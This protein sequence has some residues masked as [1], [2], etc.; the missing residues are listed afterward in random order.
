MTSDYNN[1]GHG[2]CEGDGL[3]P[4]NPD[5]SPLV[6]AWTQLLGD[7]L[8]DK[9]AQW[10]RERK[11]IE[12][13]ADQIVARL[14]ADVAELR[15]SFE[16][17]LTE[18]LAALR[19]GR[20]GASGAPGQ[21]GPPGPRGEQGAPGKMS[22]CRDWVAG[23]VHYTGDVVCH[24]GSSWQALRDTGQEPGHLDWICICAGRRNAAH[25]RDLEFRCKI[26]QAGCR[27]GGRLLLCGAR[28]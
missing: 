1:N 8:A 18:R 12:A 6:D 9:Q 11:R 27:C 20:D 7:V 4:L 15:S 26:L 10:D 19:D 25:S 23:A 21:A 17:R 13:E 24:Q 5:D 2:N 22:C 14:R 3:P 28:R 16:I